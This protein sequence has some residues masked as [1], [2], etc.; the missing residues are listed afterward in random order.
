MEFPY[1]FVDKVLCGDSLEVMKQIPSESVPAVVTDPPFGIGFKGEDSHGGKHY[2]EMGK[3]PKAYWE[4]FQPFFNEMYRIANY[5]A[6]FAIWQSQKYMRYF[7]DWYGWKE[8]IHIYAGCKN[9]VQLSKTPI[10]MGWD[11]IVMFYKGE[12]NGFTPLRPPKPKRSVDFF[13]S[14][15]AKYVTEVNSLAKKH[16]CPRQVDQTT[17]IISNFVVEK[18]LVLDPFVGV[19]LYHWFAKEQ[20]DSLLGLKC[21]QNIVSYLRRD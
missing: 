12:R 21:P 6:F 20:R 5:G 18:G 17:E 11:P 16:P 8:D 15:T 2:N 4:T 7:W 9:F 19:G 10:N 13:V 14:N 1:D 3:D